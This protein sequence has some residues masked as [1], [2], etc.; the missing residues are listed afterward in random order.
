MMAC[1]WEGRGGGEGGSPVIVRVGRRP[2]LVI[3]LR[4]EGKVGV[5]KTREEERS[6][7]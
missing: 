4:W 7:R 5:E 6:F 3:R 1:P 2:F